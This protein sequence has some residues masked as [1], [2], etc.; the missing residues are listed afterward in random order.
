MS[1]VKLGRVVPIYKGD[2]NPSNSYS[3]LDIVFD[4]TSGR[5]FIAKQPAKGNSLPTEDNIE[6]DYWGLIADKGEPGEPGKDGPAGPQGKQGSMGPSGEQGPKGDKGDLG[7]KGPQGYPGYISVKDYGAVGDK[8]NDDSSAINQAFIDASTGK[9]NG[10]NTVFIP[11]GTYLL[12]KDL[13]FQS[14]THVILDPQAV[15]YGP[16]MFFR[17]R[18]FGKGYGNGVSNV[19]VEGGTFSGDF[20]STITYAHASG[21]AFVGVLHH[22]ENITFNNVTFNMTTSDSHTFDLGG[23]RNIKIINCRFYGIKPSRPNRE[24][25]EAIQIDYSNSVGLTD[26]S[27]YEIN[28]VDGT[29][30]YNVTVAGNVFD[31]IYNDDGSIKYYAPNPIGEHASY[32][33]GHPHNIVF[34]NNTITNST[35]FNSNNQ[36]QGWIHFFS[37][38]DLKIIDNKF[39]NTKSILAHAIELSI[40]TNS[41]LPKG[42]E[43]SNDSILYDE[44]H[45]ILI[46]GNTFDGFNNKTNIQGVIKVT[47]NN[48][49]N[50]YSSNIHIKNNRLINSYPYTAKPT[51]PSIENGNDFIQVKQ[52]KSLYV[53]NNRYNYGRRL[54]TYSSDSMT[55]TTIVKVE[56]NVIE[57]SY[58]MPISIKV[59]NSTT[60]VVINNNILLDTNGF[61]SLEGISH[62]YISNNKLT[63]ILENKIADKGSWLYNVI[64]IIKNSGVIISQSN[65][66]IQDISSSE[67]YKELY[68]V[69]GYAQIKDTNSSITGGI[70]NNPIYNYGRNLLLDSKIAKIT[71]TS[72]ISETTPVY[73][74]TPELSI[75]KRLLSGSK[76]TMSFDVDIRNV[77]AVITNEPGIKIRAVF[78]VTF[79]RLDGSKLY[80][81]CG[82]D[83]IKVGDSYRGRVVATIDATNENF[84]DNPTI[85]QGIY[86]QRFTAEYAHIS[87]PKI[88]IGTNSTDYSIAPE[89]IDTGNYLD[90]SVDEKYDDVSKTIYYVTKWG[91]K[92]TNGSPVKIKVGQSLNSNNEYEGQP[93]PSEFNRLHPRSPIV[94]NT[95]PVFKGHTIINGTS[96]WESHNVIGRETL[97]IDKNGDLR[98]Y[99]SSVTNSELI[100]K[101]VMQATY[102]FFTLVKD[103]V[104][105]DYEDIAKLNSGDTTGYDYLKQ[106]HPR[107]IIG[108]TREGDYIL[109]TSDGRHTN[110]VGFTLD[111]CVRISLSEGLYFSFNLDG[112]GSVNTIVNNSKVGF[113]YDNNGKTEREVSSLIHVEVDEGNNT[114]DDAKYL[115]SVKAN[116]AYI[117]NF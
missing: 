44:H 70:I 1:E 41:K 48:V 59:T 24:Y 29:P 22:N 71:R 39:I 47:G 12:K 28:N 53:S 107:Q 95:A 5:S 103:G 56:D 15:L 106:T 113:L 110:S 77:T 40:S 78:E 88:E 58:Y 3:E 114:F 31:A 23:C 8:I 112:G 57:N 33:D 90:I 109:I 67:R 61:I 60:D 89:E 34:K 49:T 38:E 14:N 73:W 117:N 36:I 108:Q 52:V 98:A 11:K 63:P 101:G 74:Q 91:K 19:T 116:Q 79:V 86:L 94:F 17:F 16:G 105:Y 83:N 43:T 111:D 65:D 4:N 69:D 45:D 46:S 32:S 85:G 92:T 76:F 82:I 26:K 72:D 20:D 99:P 50:Y 68:S 21:N 7:P 9:I 66:V 54:L 84:E 93:L 75:S 37:I 10:L 18:S 115:A 30:T 62:A 100:S 81:H 87:N 80:A 64:S 25:V 102:G 35:T 97:T 104:K 27:N 55:D 51:N 6:N 2:Y 42:S 13:D 96:I